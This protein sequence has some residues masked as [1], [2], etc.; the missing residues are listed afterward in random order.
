MKTLITAVIASAFSFGA[1]AAAH[2][3]KGASAPMAKP[4][5]SSAMGSDMAA[6]G[7]KADKHM[8]KDMKKDTMKGA[9][10]PKA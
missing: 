10:A 7:A 3:E 1:V 6:S 8:K 9:S 2:M 5:A 4:A